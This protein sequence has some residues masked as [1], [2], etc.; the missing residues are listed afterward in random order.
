MVCAGNEH[1]SVLLCEDVEV[2]T[3]RWF[4]ANTSTP[5]ALLLHQ[6]CP[7]SFL[8]FL[9]LSWL[10]SLLKMSNDV[11]ISVSLHLSMSDRKQE[12]DLCVCVCTCV[13]ARACE[14]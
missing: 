2:C 3:S 13:C 10:V 7:S 1:L 14:C 6:S 11:V 8:F 5:F 12:C 9:S 4:V